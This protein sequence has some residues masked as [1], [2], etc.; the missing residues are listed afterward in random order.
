VN[1][2]R[3]KHV[4]VVE[5]DS[6]IRSIIHDVL[7]E[8]GLR[9]TTF[10]DGESLLALVRGHHPDLVILD[11]MLPGIQ[12]LDVLRKLQDHGRIP[13]IVV[14]GKKA[15]TDRILGLELGAD[16]YLVKPFSH[17]ELLARV[18][19]LLRRTGEPVS[20]EI[21]DFGEITIDLRTRDVAVEG[22]M[23]DL[24]A[25]EFDLLAFLAASPR[26]V[27]S[28]EVLLDRVWGSSGEWQ[29]TATVSE[30]I[31]RL[32]RKIESDPA[33]PRRIQTLRGAGYRFVP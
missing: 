13:V 4:V 18:H 33:E 12:G 22:R 26:Q 5:D 6:E 23:V 19:A 21:L 8:D 9:V 7:V 14:S 31:H 11:L 2:A 32:R 30:H 29:T 15:E 3:V 16:D 25:L 24:T 27:F 20:S 17:H 10:G 1:K 28:R